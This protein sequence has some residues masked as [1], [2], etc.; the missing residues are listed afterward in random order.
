MLLVFIILFFLSHPHYSSPFLFCFSSFLIIPSIPFLVHARLMSFYLLILFHTRSP[1]ESN[2]YSDLAA[3]LP[4]HFLA[5]ARDLSSQSPSSRFQSLRPHGPTH[6]QHNNPEISLKEVQD[7]S[8]SWFIY[9]NILSP[10]EMSKLALGPHTDPT[11]N[12]TG[13]FPPPAQTY[14]VGCETNL[15]LPNLTLPSYRLR[16][17][18]TTYFI[19]L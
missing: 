16:T 1:V 7:S 17:N 19:P 4:V 3:G 2:R 5:E 12:R 14:R 10:S 13:G 18:R 6:S 9:H 15:T 11:S 8:C